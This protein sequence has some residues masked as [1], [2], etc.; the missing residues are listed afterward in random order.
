MQSSTVA[1][2]SCRRDYFTRAK[3]FLKAPLTVVC[4]LSLSA[5]GGG[6]SAPASS[7]SVQSDEVLQSRFAEFVVSGL[8]FESAGEI[9]V[10]DA[11]GYFSYRSGQTIRF[12][13]GNIDLG[14]F[15][16]SL[17]PGEEVSLAELLAGTLPVDRASL[18]KEL[19]FKNDVTPFDY[20]VNVMSLLYLL[21]Q[22]GD[23]SNGIQ[24]GNLNQ[25]LDGSALNLDLA[26]DKL[27]ASSA[28]RRLAALHGGRL[29]S[30]YLEIIRLAYAGLGIDVPGQR[31]LKLRISEQDS[32]GASQQ[33]VFDYDYDIEG[34]IES[35]TRKENDDG[36]VQSETVYDWKDDKFDCYTRT[37]YLDA[38]DNTERCHAYDSEGQLSEI[39]RTNAQIYA[40]SRQ[41]NEH[42]QVIE[43][44]VSL[45]Q[46]TLTLFDQ[47]ITQDF[48]QMARLKQI[49]Y[50]DLNASEQ[51]PFV[52]PE[53]FP[54]LSLNEYLRY[55]FF[56]NE[57]G[58]LS[59][60]RGFDGDDLSADM[61]QVLFYTD[62]L[63]TRLETDRQSD[64]IVDMIETR[65]YDDMRNLAI[66][67]R[68]TDAQLYPGFDYLESY[69]F[70]EIGN[71]LTKTAEQT[72]PVSGEKR[73]IV[74]SY[75]FEQ[76]NHLIEALEQRF[77]DD[78]Q[79][80]ERIRTQS[81][82]YQ[83]QNDGLAEILKPR[84]SQL[85]D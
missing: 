79:V 21:D 5:C 59:E 51:L 15:N 29:H 63:L 32:N 30:D 60:I 83:N 16:T 34:L 46:D 38:S 65:Q 48:D 23:I 71:L 78:E 35:R 8:Q 62:G 73:T 76:G 77:V 40:E 10:T 2:C 26:M 53:D 58:Q 1:K 75:S 68:D 22:D 9:G 28:Y 3:R 64:G 31:I 4:A 54:A 44:H 69:E 56:Y 33:A 17:I 50:T 55:E 18:L 14:E 42:G 84:I 27:D 41:Y 6:S 11:E 82:V 36:D 85:P 37:N 61:I 20:A 39:V 74:Q 43:S 25:S 81:F 19:Q 49:T 12:S 57:L 47:S 45:Q 67:S 13:L 7:G 66:L 72:H 24:L 80:Y 70:D 52:L